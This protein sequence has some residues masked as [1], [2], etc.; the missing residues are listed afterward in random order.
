MTTELEN[1]TVLIVGMGGLGC[2]AA[3]ALAKAGVGRLLL[4]DEDLIEIENLHRQVL[5]EAKDVG[6]PKVE[7]ARDALLAQGAKSFSPRRLRFVPENAES[8]VR[9]ADVLVEGADNFATKFLACDAARLVGRP[10]VHG[11]AIRWHGTAL[12]TRPSGG[13]CYRCL[14][15]D[16]LP[17]ELAPACSTAGVVGP[18]VGLVGALMADLALDALLGR[19]ERA[20]QA[21]SVDGKRRKF[22][23]SPVFARKTC[24]TCGSS[25][26]P[27]RPL[28]RD[29]YL[30]PATLS[31][32]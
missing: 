22:R 10:V 2:P 4:V 3:L 19:F 5:Y 21:L 14:F 12:L 7:R 13:P 16:L 25:E 26:G 11:A 6:Q 9:E 18:I 29:R 20:G 23:V 31:A 17:D 15:E 27:P 32:L 28:S 24:S 1:Q 8:L 30:A